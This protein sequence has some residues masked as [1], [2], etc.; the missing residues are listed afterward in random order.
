MEFPPRQDH[1]L[2]F[3]AG[4]YLPVGQGGQGFLQSDPYLEAGKTGAETQVPTCSERQVP[5]LAPESEA[6]G[7]G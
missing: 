3:A 2:D 5:G 6:Q 7:I 4:R 1:G